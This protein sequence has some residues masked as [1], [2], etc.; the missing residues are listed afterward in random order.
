MDKK[1][2]IFLA[3]IIVIASAQIISPKEPTNEPP[4]Y[5]I[6]KSYLHFDNLTHMYERSEYVIH[7]V[8]ESSLVDAT[9]K[10]NIHTMHTINVIEVLKGNNTDSIVV[11]QDGGV[12]NGETIR[13]K[14]EPMMKVGDELV[15]YLAYNPSAESYV[16]MGG[17]QGRFLIQDGKLYHI[18][19]LDKSIQL[20]TPSLWTKGADASNLRQV[21]TP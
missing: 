15:L 7:G 13:V 5:H 8:V 12:Y 1:I 9:F 11:R 21:L 17:P 2:I 6:Y 14:D 19:E 10:S 3:V 16:V 18:T 4:L 20:V